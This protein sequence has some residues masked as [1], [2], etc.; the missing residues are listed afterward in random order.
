MP[1]A[2]T[3]Q[4][5]LTR[6]LRDNQE[7]ERLSKVEPKLREAVETANSVPLRNRGQFMLYPEVR[8]MM[9][10]KAIAEADDITV[11][12]F[13]RNAVDAA[14]EQRLKPP[15]TRRKRNTTKKGA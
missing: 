3:R 6:Q 1:E 8:T 9:I 13:I 12:D 5:E 11:Q 15:R 2:Q 10:L 14:I 4:E 7:K